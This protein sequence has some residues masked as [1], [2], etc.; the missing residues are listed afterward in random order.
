MDVTA[1]GIGATQMLFAAAALA[2]LNAPTSQKHARKRTMLVS[3]IHMSNAVL[4]VDVI[5]SSICI[6]AGRRE[7]VLSVDLSV[8]LGFYLF[9]T[10]LGFFALDQELA[11]T[12]SDLTFVWKIWSIEAIDFIT[13]L[14]GTFYDVG[15]VVVSCRRFFFVSC[16]GPAGL[17]ICGYPTWT[18]STPELNSA[19]H[20]FS[21]AMLMWTG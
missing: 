7:E 2:V 18:F 16:R 17:V 14:Y 3:C 10:S 9:A 13:I 21:G 6:M 4:V 12:K 1:F 20:F 15:V 11:R 19:H 8:K 5:F